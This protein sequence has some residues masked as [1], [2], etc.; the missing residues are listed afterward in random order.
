MI[1]SQTYSGRLR[2]LRVLDLDLDFFQNRIVYWGDES[3]G[4]P[5]DDEAQPWDTAAVR[6]FLE[7]RCGLSSAAPVPGA[8]VRTHD[9]V[10]YAWRALIANGQLRAPFEVV[11]V[12]A[13]AD[14]GLGDAG[15][16]YVMGNLLHQPLAARYDPRQG[17]DGLNE[18]NF[19]VFALACRWISRL[20][21]V[22]PIGWI[23]D[24][25][26]YH[27]EHFDTASGMLQLK[28]YFPW[29]LDEMDF[30]SRHQPASV[31][32]RVPFELITEPV[33][34]GDPPFDFV[35]LTHSPAYTSSGTD[36]FVP[37]IRSYIAETDL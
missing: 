8:Y 22:A 9:E 19:L 10:F 23:D 15:W 16:A 14:L 6:H 21:F 12:D 30:S 32:E 36:Q 33:Y 24:L 28:A 7:V 17:C 31:E 20:T 5:S 34:L 27:F 4:R 25:L 13:H 18:G 26:R 1:A 3:N 11:H 29:Q 37:L 2:P 35:F